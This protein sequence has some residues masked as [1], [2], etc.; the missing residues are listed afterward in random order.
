[1]HQYYP[2]N[3]VIYEVQEQTEH[4]YICYLKYILYF[5]I[6]VDSGSAINGISVGHHYK[7]L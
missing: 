5:Y 2:A 6:V 7:I 1:M 3:N 4:V